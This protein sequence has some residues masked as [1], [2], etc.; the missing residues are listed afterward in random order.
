[1]SFGKRLMG[2][3]NA[4]LGEEEQKTPPQATDIT[5]LAENRVKE[6]DERMKMVREQATLAGAT[7]T[8]LMKMVIRSK[9]LETRGKRLLAEAQQHQSS[10]NQPATNAAMSQAQRCMSEYA[11]LEASIATMTTQAQTA[12]VNAKNGLKTLMAEARSASQSMREAPILSKI[13]SIN[14]QAKR[15][16]MVEL[17]QLTA[18]QKFDEAKERILIEAQVNQALASVS[19]GVGGDVDI[20]GEIERQQIS[21]I[22]GKWQAEIEAGQPVDAEYEVVEGSSAT[23][24]ALQFLEQPPLGGLITHTPIPVSMKKPSQKP[25]PSPQA[26]EAP[27]ADN[28]DTQQS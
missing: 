12:D 3:V 8:E 9:A 25:A 7:R 22:Q 15:M 19:S 10:G 5:S 28:P 11:L 14:E 13:E 16:Q 21:S 18:G 24:S 1:M 17:K 27:P 6:L 23:D 4:I 2:I 26:E 20:S